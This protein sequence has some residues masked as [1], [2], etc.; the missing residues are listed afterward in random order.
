MA[1]PVCLSPTPTLDLQSAEGAAV[2][3]VI[4]DL[5]V[6]T[7]RGDAL[8]Y[9]EEVVTVVSQQSPSVRPVY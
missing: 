7:N 1:I 6:S 5:F 4:R 9:T 3:A 2:I 8:L